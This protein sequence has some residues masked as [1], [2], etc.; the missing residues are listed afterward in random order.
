MYGLF[1]SSLEQIQCQ[2][3]WWKD[4]WC[5][6]LIRNDYLA[7]GVN[8]VKKV[9]WDHKGRVLITESALKLAVIS[10]YAVNGTDNPYKDPTTAQLNG[11]RHD[12]KLTFHKLLLETC[13]QYEADGW[14]VVL[15]GDKNISRTRFDS[16]PYLRTTPQHVKN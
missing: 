2:R 12:R 7:S 3:I 8:K 9:D 5:C 14:C 13:Q 16:H 11:T 1:L 15:A 10:V 4:L 6:P